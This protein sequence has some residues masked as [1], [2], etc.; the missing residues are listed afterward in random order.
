VVD[1]DVPHGAEGHY[2][3]RQIGQGYRLL[4]PV[5]RDG[6]MFHGGN[7]LSRG[8]HGLQR[9]AG[10]AQV[11]KLRH[12]VWRAFRIC[13]RI[14]GYGKRAANIGRDHASHPAAKIRPMLMVA[15]AAM[16]SRPQSGIG[17]R[18]GKSPG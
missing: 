7:A 14:I 10:A 5:R 4:A 8:F 15:L 2:I 3:R 12:A 11:E 18:A 16:A 17:S 13:Q 9:Q 6:G 1:G